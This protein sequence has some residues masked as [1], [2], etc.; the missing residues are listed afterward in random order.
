MGLDEGGLVEKLLGMFIPKWAL[1]VAALLI[2]AWFLFSGVAR[3]ID[4]ST[5]TSW[6]GRQIQGQVSAYHEW[7]IDY[8]RTDGQTVQVP[9][10]TMSERD[11]AKFRR[12]ASVKAKEV[13]KASKRAWWE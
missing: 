7:G 10:K 13:E 8:L 3:P 9:Y 2:G 11:A 1:M 5:V 6:D 4:T 12:A